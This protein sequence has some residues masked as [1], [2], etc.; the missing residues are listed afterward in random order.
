MFT[1]HKEFHKQN[2][3]QI[4]QN[5]ISEFY[6]IFLINGTKYLSI[7]IMVQLKE[8]AQMRNKQLLQ[9]Q[10]SV[11]MLSCIYMHIK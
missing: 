3:Y 11:C 2:I 4:L 10:S 5:F 8:Q 1:L 7:K 9:S 6:P